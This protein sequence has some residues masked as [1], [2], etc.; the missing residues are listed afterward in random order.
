M[1]RITIA[2][3]FLGFALIVTGAAWIYRPLGPLAAG[4]M[5][6]FAAATAARKTS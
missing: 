4:T 1:N 3:F 2:A 5:F 6:L